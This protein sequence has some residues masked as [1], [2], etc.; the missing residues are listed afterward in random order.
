M[1]LITHENIRP[2][3]CIHDRRF[4]SWLAVC[5]FPELIRRLRLHPCLWW[6]LS[7]F[8]SSS[9]DLQTLVSRLFSSF[10]AIISLIYMRISKKNDLGLDWTF[11]CK[12][13]N[14]STQFILSRLK[15]RIRSNYV[16]LSWW[17]WN[18]L[19]FIGKNNCC[20]FVLVLDL[21]FGLYFVWASPYWIF[22]FHSKLINK[23]LFSISC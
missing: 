20:V 14:I 1:G 2:L 13:L 18:I 22:W 16:R 8:S 4:F 5:L 3:F 10:I 6:V 21:G 12:A 11:N 9:Y 19:L 23:K 7:S 17:N 15:Y